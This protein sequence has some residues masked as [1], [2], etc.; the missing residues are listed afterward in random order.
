MWRHGIGCHM[1]STSPLERPTSRWGC[2][3][4]ASCSRSSGCCKVQ[5]T[6]TCASD[7]SWSTLSALT[8]AQPCATPWPHSPLPT[9][10][11]SPPLGPSTSATRTQASS[12]IR[13]VGLAG[14]AS[15]SSCTKT[16]PRGT[17]HGCNTP[18]TSVVSGI[19][20]ATCIGIPRTDT[21]GSTPR[22]FCTREVTKIDSASDTTPRHSDSTTL[23]PVWSS[24]PSS[25]R[26]PR[27]VFDCALPRT[28]DRWR[29]RWCRLC[30][31]SRRHT[32]G[33]TST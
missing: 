1:A 10:A 19:W 11:T 15:G 4:R 20:T 29:L 27:T 23:A 2:W 12:S 13:T 7:T 28:C 25:A 24:P 18:S 8:L 31:S 32:G 16:R 22:S 3:R 21:Q 26:P 33:S 14:L 5:L 17:N 9:S 30:A 6:A